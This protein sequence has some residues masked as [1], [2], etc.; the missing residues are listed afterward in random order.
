LIQ[1][2][3]PRID[4]APHPSAARSRLPDL[5]GSRLAWA[6]WWLTLALAVAGLVLV[7]AE[8][9]NLKLD[10]QNFPGYASLLAV[11]FG[12]I[13]ARL[14]DRHPKN[15][16]GWLLLANGLAY[17]VASVVFEYQALSIGD[18]GRGLPTLEAARRLGVAS[19]YV[20]T[21][22]SGFILLTFP[23]GR[24][25]SRR[26]AVVATPLGL[27]IAVLV[28]AALSG[29]TVGFLSSDGILERV[30]VALV[31]L[32]AAS[33][34]LRLIRAHGTER[35][36]LKWVVSA[37]AVATAAFL[38]N[39]FGNQKLFE[40]IETLAILLF[41]ISVGIAMQRYR[42]YDI[43]VILHRAAVY[44]TLTALLT[45]VSSATWVF[46]QR[47]FFAL[48]GQTSELAI[49]MTTIVLIAIFAPLRE[50]V[51]RQIDRWVKSPSPAPR[52]LRAFSDSVR[53]FVRL[54][55]RTQLLGELLNEAITSLDASG[56][57]LELRQAGGDWRR[58]P[59]DTWRGH[60]QV[61]VSFDGAGSDARLL[62]GPRR[63]GRPYSTDQLKAL[64]EASAAVE[65]AIHR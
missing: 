65:Q 23:T 15:P 32:S 24:L 4:V 36:Q 33:L 22:L 64:Q 52:G 27:V 7:L 49:I 31:A 30:A 59:P 10:R 61:T 38:L 55:D 9:S 44:I 63:S 45:G 14:A 40:V 46:I 26:W 54:N 5:S 12:I 35:Q 57:A 21:M 6:I 58:V 19:G 16:V 42:L 8:L 13:G 48:T 39:Y 43:D 28:L 51:Q 56:G 50:A 25:P 41:P 18:P 62:L 11:G 60:P 3:A 34:V 47:L 2:S 17:A 1:A 20:I 37:G 53:D 29:S